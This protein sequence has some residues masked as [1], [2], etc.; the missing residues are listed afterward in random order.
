MS[1][2]SDSLKEEIEAGRRS[3][4]GAFR[5]LL[6]FAKP[7][8]NAIIWA[9]GLLI[10]SSLASVFSARLLGDLV[11]KGIKAY[12]GKDLAGQSM[13]LALEFGAA[14]IFLELTSVAANYFGRRSLSDSSL[15]TI[16]RIR[17]KLFAHLQDLPMSFFDKHP[18]GRTVTRLTHDVDGIEDFF[19]NA[20]ARLLGAIISLII[21]MAA[22]LLTDL[23]MGLILMAAVIPAILVTYGIRHIV[24][25]CNREMAH[26]NS[27][28]NAKLWEFLSGILVIRG[29]GAE[30]WSQN[31]FDDV[32][33]DHLTASIRLNV[34]NSWSRPIILIL[35]QMPLILLFIFGGQMVFAGTLSVG[36]FVTFKVF[37]DRFS[38]PVSALAQE[39]HLIQTAFVNTER[40][41]SFLSRPTEAST[42]GANGTLTPKKL[43]GAIS[44]KN[45]TMSY[46]LR[47]KKVLQDLNF[48]VQ[49]GERVGLAGRTGS[50]K[51]TTLGLL[52]RLYEFQTGEIL[53]DGVDIRKYE[54]NWLREKIGYVSQDVVIFKGK[55]RENLAFGHLIADDEILRLCKKTGLFEVFKQRGLSLDSEILDQGSN[56]SLGERQLIALTRVLIKDPSILIMDEATANI[57]PKS[58]TLIGEAVHS[59]MKG[60]SCFLIAHRL[61]TLKE[62]DRIM[63]FRDGRL[64]ENAP[65]EELLKSEGY[66][67]NLVKSGEQMMLT[68]LPETK[69]LN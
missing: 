60:R 40:V 66:Y 14:I 7:F 1:F 41:T 64:V 37:C 18:L 17:E 28:I 24:R 3:K 10:L 33:E 6:G 36:L 23:K 43:N 58:E 61:A 31:I 2:E 34:L 39:I 51:T 9:L 55:L 12:A 44:F 62:C 68:D 29:F 4:V 54:R 45:V 53:I 56:L 57:D 59:V 27:T 15:S 69:S 25:D 42:L 30:R 67:S 35:S 52:A 48:E 19:S 65:H 8:R 26:K 50:G 16:Y 49:P 20:L 63:V 21:V 32:V 22:M 13:A 47:G 38:R 46:D 11:E 5:H